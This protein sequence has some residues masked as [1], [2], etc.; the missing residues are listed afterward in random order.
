MDTGLPI[1]QG[2]RWSNTSLS[3]PE[4]YIDAS[5]QVRLGIADS[6]S[7]GGTWGSSTDSVR[8]ILEN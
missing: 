1:V 7:G 4:R 5:G 2:F 8:G 3:A 6:T